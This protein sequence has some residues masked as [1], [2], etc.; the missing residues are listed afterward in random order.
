[1]S[2]LPPPQPRLDPDSAG[3]WTHA[4]EGR[5]S[6]QRCGSC[7]RW[8]FP[9]VERCRHC[10]GALSWQPVSGRGTVHT[11]IVQHHNVAPGFDALRPYVIA[12]V[13]PDEAPHVR[14]PA[15]LVDV[16]PVKLRIGA[17]VEAV[18]VPL[19]GG[20]IRVPV[21]RLQSALTEG[22]MP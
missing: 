11:F 13:S 5:L 21:F 3:Y 9:P 12:L 7:A 18:I 22:S 1:M 16:D 17:P 2:A 10:D 19:P 8:Q 4:S 15:R 14:L 6:L 20:E